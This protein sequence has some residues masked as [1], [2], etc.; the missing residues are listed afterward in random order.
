MLKKRLEITAHPIARDALPFQTG[1]ELAGDGVEVGQQMR[2]RVTRRLLHR[3]DFHELV[4]DRQVIAVAVDRRVSDEIIQVRVM[5]ERRR[6]YCRRVVVDEVAEESEGV[7][8]PEP[9]KAEVA[10]LHLDG[11]GLVMECPNRP[12]EFRFDEGECLARGQPAAHRVLRCTPKVPKGRARAGAGRR[13][14]QHHQVQREFV[15]V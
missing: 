2:K 9:F 4:A 7:G 12:I 15:E 5:R 11:V 1:D 8:F 10:Q 6:G 13:L 14:V 3:Q